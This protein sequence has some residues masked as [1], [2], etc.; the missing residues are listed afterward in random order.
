LVVTDD[1]PKIFQRLTWGLVP[2]FVRNVAHPKEL[3]WNTLNCIGENMFDTRSFQ[4]SARHRRCLI[5]FDGF[6]EPHHYQGKSYPFF[7]EH[8]DSE[9][10][11]VA[12]LWDDNGMVQGVSLVTVSASPLLRRIHNEKERMPLILP[13]EF[14]DEWLEHGELEKERVMDLVKPYDDDLLKART[15]P[16]IRSNKKNGWVSP[17]D[18]PEAWEEFHYADMPSDHYQAILH[19]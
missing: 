6:Y 17:G 4:D 9:P 10:L 5:F 7:I 15:V 19:G 13:K 18:A 14:K 16:P 8:A 12:G 1:K 11:I 3:K 2:H